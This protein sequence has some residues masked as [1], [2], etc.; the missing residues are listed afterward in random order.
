[1]KRSR[2]CGKWNPLETD[3]TR[4]NCAALGIPGYFDVIETPM[5]LTI[6]MV[7]ALR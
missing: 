6:I 5:N 2:A 4:E 3:I 7:C 1:V